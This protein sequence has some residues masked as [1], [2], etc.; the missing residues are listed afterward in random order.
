MHSPRPGAL[1]HSA[2]LTPLALD[3]RFPSTLSLLILSV[4]AVAEPHAE[5]ELQL[6]SRWFSHEGYSG[7]ARFQ[8]SLAFRGELVLNPTEADQIVFSPFFRLDREDARRTHAD[9][10]ELYWSHVEDRWE[11]N[12]GVR[13]VFW[14]VTEFHHLVDIINQT[15]LVE[16]IDD[17]DSLGQPMVQLSLVRDWGIVDLFL[18]AGSRERTFAGRDGRLVFPLKIDEARATYESAAE[19]RRL[20]GAV[21]WSASLGGLELAVHHFS[22]T[23]RDPEFRINADGSRLVPHYN[24][25]DQTGV[26]AQ[27]LTGN[28]A[29]KL[30]AL[31]RT[32]DG[33]RYEAF[34]A[35]FERTLVGVF[36]SDLDVGVVMEYMYD[37]RD[38]LA[39]NTIFEHDL[40]LGARLA[41]NDVNESN[42]LVGLIWDTD[43]GERV[44]SVEAQRQLGEDWLLRMEARAFGGSRRVP[45][46]QPL[47]A[48]TDLDHRAGFLEREDF[49]QLELTRYF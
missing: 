31:T 17:E 13:Q 9:V 25:I 12:A 33:D 38:E 1:V 4:S 36:D 23:G 11:L 8:P 22:G 34:V 16:N 26:D 46:D 39:F 21:R 45:N 7:Q 6:Q 14:G 29:F 20:D 48:L 40:A 41:L 49:V 3:L 5:G 10:R 35:G 44:F 24:V 42:A 37:E 47:S 32:G 27:Y 15:D 30:E 18:L 19:D 28:W 43:T 2:L